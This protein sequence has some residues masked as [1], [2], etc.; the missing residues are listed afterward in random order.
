MTQQAK[1]SS[2]HLLPVEGLGEADF[3][4]KL[5][6][7]VVVADEWASS[8][9]GQHLLVCLI[10][11]LC[12]QTDLV[13]EIEVVCDE[14]PLQVR[15]PGDLKQD[16]LLQSIGA[17]VEWAVATEVRICFRSR[18]TQADMTI[19][20]GCPDQFPFDLPPESL[21]AIG[22]GWLAWIG[23][24]DNVLILPPNFGH[25]VKQRWPARTALG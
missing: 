22:A 11:L 6:V 16:T 10:N 12:R 9:A 1:I 23:I 25:P 13:E 20:I 8:C 24:A 7:S 3:A 15:C 17:L 2:R 5:R 14:Q 4:R 21:F 19:A 18:P